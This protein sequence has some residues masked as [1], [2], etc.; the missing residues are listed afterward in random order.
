M[1]IMVPDG[2]NRVPPSAFTCCAEALSADARTIAI[3]SAS[4]LAEEPDMNFPLFL[5]RFDKKYSRPETII[6]LELNQTSG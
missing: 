5:L 6:F 1:S 4:V 3:D 2:T